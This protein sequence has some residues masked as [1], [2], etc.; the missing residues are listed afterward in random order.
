MKLRI[1]HI[2]TSDKNTYAIQWVK[3]DN[4]NSMDPNIG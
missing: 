1:T 3:Q 4:M 2:S